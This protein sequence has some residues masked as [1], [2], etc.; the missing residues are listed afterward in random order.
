MQKV[1]GITELLEQIL[2][3]LPMRDIFLTQAVSKRCRDLIQTSSVLRAIIW[4]PCSSASAVDP[5]SSTAK[6]NPFKWGMITHAINFP[7]KAWLVKGASWRETQLY[8]PGC[9][10]L[11]VRICCANH[12]DFRY[13]CCNPW[14]LLQINRNYLGHFY[15]SIYHLKG[16][17]RCTSDCAKVKIGRVELGI[18]KE[19]QMFEFCLGD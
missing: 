15:D 11:R 19:S 5:V 9:H 1:F 16:N 3:H 10:G 2:S 17:W 8:S 18:T 13:Y 12:K 6:I 14:S 4:L 7:E